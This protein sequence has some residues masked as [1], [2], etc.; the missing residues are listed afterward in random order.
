MVFAAAGIMAAAMRR[1]AIAMRFI[2]PP[3][4]RTD[5]MDT[6][7]L[8]AHKGSTDL[9]EHFFK[10]EPF[11]LQILHRKNPMRL[12]CGNRP[13]LFR[14][15]MQ[16]VMIRWR[17]GFVSKRRMC[18]NQMDAPRFHDNRFIHV[19]QPESSFHRQVKT[20]K[21]ISGKRFVRIPENNLFP[22]SDVNQF[23]IQSTDK[24]REAYKLHV[25]ADLHTT[26]TK[27]RAEE[28]RIVR[29]NG[30]YDDLMIPRFLNLLK[31]ILLLIPNYGP[32]SGIM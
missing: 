8:H 25:D 6:P 19:I 23:R 27:R 2:F 20:I 15:K 21:I 26:N 13:E 11:F 32:I 16:P 30:F 28:A 31:R 24:A 18:R 3:L 9:T 17:H 5:S 29:N 10:F 22:K 14:Q 4:S 1:T 12:K 7:P